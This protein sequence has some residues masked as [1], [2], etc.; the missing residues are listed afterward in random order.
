MPR[1]PER[2]R[3]RAL[4]ALGAASYT[5]FCLAVTTAIARE[6]SEPFDAGT[7]AIILAI[8][9]SLL[10]WR[11][12]PEAALVAIVAGLFAYSVLGYAGGPIYLAP[13]APLA[14]I[15]ATGDR[16]RTAM[17]A[18]A[19]VGS[20]ALYALAVDRSLQHVPHV[21]GF[22]GWAV[23]A[24]FIGSAYHNRRA[25]IDE[26]RQRARDLEETREEEARRRVVEERL[27]IARDLH[28][29]IAHGIA[30][31]HMQA[32]AGGRVLDQSPEQARTALETIEQV[33][34]QTLDELRTTVG[35]LRADDDG[36][37][38]TPT[39]GIDRLPALV[40]T[41]RDAGLAVE[42]RC[43]DRTDPVPTAVDV[44]A[45]RIVQESLTN[46]MR[47]AGT[48]A[49]AVV[50]VVHE[51]R[52]LVVEV[53]DDGLGVPP[54]RLPGG[55]GIAGMRER[56]ETVGGELRVGPRHGGGFRVWARLPFPGSP[57]PS[58]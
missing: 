17:S 21:L 35:V 4:D 28:D 46:V 41:A 32:A 27:R 55:H 1:I 53:C 7:V 22:A 29:V 49:H 2:L 48:P 11:R 14:A 16:R 58:S 19:T 51:P 6:N 30:T 56:A 18:G 12:R 54:D 43:D 57:V 44:A 26:L 5:G 45:F 42:L 9:A 40:A 3:G 8:G 20:F 25:W 34:K 13:L 52:A 37:P 23:G 50:S 10:W 38:R 33:S 36:A 47:H 15:A 24:V 31:I 39:P